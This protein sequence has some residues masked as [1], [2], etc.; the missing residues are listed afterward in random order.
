MK[1]FGHNDTKKLI[2]NMAN[3]KCEEGI[4]KLEYCDEYHS[5][6]TWWQVVDK[7]TNLLRK[8]ALKLFAIVPHSASC[9]RVFSG[10]GWFCANRRQNLL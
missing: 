3:F 8:I 4:Y 5:P 10:L 2:A 9:E 6:R 7:D 1:N